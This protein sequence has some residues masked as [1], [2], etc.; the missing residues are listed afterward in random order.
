MRSSD[1]CRP[2]A[3]RRATTITS[4]APRDVIFCV[5][6]LSCDFCD[7][8]VSGISRGNPSKFCC[9]PEILKLYAKKV[10]TC[11]ETRVV[12]LEE[13][14]PICNGQFYKREGDRA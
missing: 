8:Q 10:H 14:W 6:C 9:R 2:E 3:G 13:A 12:S 4:V 7:F 5:T 11:Y 1:P